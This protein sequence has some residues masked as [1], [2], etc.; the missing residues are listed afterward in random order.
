MINNLILA[1]G[2]LLGS[3]FF[4]VLMV[5]NIRYVKNLKKEQ[6]EKKE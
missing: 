2:S 3:V 5:N 1:I 4:I 6:R